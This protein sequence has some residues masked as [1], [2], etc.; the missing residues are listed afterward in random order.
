[1]AEQFIYHFLPGDRPALATDPEAWTP[2]DERVSTEH[3]ER[4]RQ[5]AADGTVVLAGRS[6]DGI[7]PA[8]VIFEAASQEEA[9]A[10][11]E[12]DPFLSSGLFRASLHPFRVAVARRQ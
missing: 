8:V 6:Q 9:Q 2:E 11:M 7:G 4:L 3:F 12:A 1:M 10:F 5:A